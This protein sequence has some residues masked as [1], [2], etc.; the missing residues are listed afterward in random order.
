MTPIINDLPA[1]APCSWSD[2]LLLL[3]YA[4]PKIWTQ[5]NS[6][7]FGIYWSEALSYGRL[8]PEPTEAELNSFYDTP[9]YS[10]YL[11]GNSNKQTTNPKPSLLSR[12]LVKIAW[13]SDHGVN[14]PLPT[15]LSMTEQNLPRFA[16]SG[17]VAGRFYRGCATKARYQ[18]VSIL[19]RLAPRFCAQS[20]SN[21]I[22][23]LQ[24][25]CQQH[26]AIDTSMLSP[27][28]NP[29]STAANRLRQFRM[30]CLC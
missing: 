28:S 20:A 17:A 11:A 19:I 18:P 22:L 21:F 6:R 8:W 13:V 5:Q 23:A 16:T 3:K 12:I 24:K 2:D 25:H 15:I 26:Y 7:A 27:C 4:L 9:D 10:D 1:K 14:D 29:L 30:P